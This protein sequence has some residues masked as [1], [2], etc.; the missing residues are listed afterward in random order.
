M[1]NY[2]PEATR[3]RTSL[4]PPTAPSDLTSSLLDSLE[5][6]GALGLLHGAPLPAGPA[7]DATSTE[8][9]LELEAPVNPSQRSSTR[10]RIDTPRGAALKEEL[11]QSEL[12]RKKR[13]PR[14]KNKSKSDDAASTT[15]HSNYNS[16]AG[17]DQSSYSVHRL[18]GQDAPTSNGGGAPSTVRGQGDIRQFLQPATAGAI[19]KLHG[20]PV[21]NSS[22]H[23]GEDSE[24][25]AAAA[26]RVSATS[27]ASTTPASGS[28]PPTSGSCAPGSSPRTS[29]TSGNRSADPQPSTST[30]TNTSCGSTG[31]K[32]S[33]STV[34]LQA[35]SWNFNVGRQQLIDDIK[36]FIGYDA[37]QISTEN[38]KAM[39]EAIVR[40]QTPAVASPERQA[41][42][43]LLRKNPI[44]VGGGHHINRPDLNPNNTDT[45][46]ESESEPE[47]ESEPELIAPQ[48][49]RAHAGARQIDLTLEPSQSPSPLPRSHLPIC[50][51]HGTPGSTQHSTQPTSGTGRWNTTS[52]ISLG[53]PPRPSPLAQ[54]M[55]RASASSQRSFGKSKAQPTS[56]G[57]RILLAGP[58]LAPSRNTSHAPHGLGVLRP[59]DNA[60]QPVR[61]TLRDHLTHTRAHNAVRAVREEAAEQQATKQPAVGSTPPSPRRLSRHQRR[62]RLPPGFNNAVNHIASQLRAHD[63]LTARRLNR[64]S[65]TSSGDTTLPEQTVDGTGRRPST[66]DL[67]EDNEAELAAAGAEASGSELRKSGRK[68]KPAARDVHGNERYILTM[69]KMHLFAYALMEGSYQTRGLFLRWSLPVFEETWSQE[70]PGVAYE[71]PSHQ[72]LQVMVNSLATYRCKVKEAL[73]PLVQYAYGFDKPASTPAAINRNIEIF[74]SIHPNRFHCIDY[75]PPYGHYESD[76]LA[77][78]IAV[79][80]FGSPSS[81]GVMFRSFFSPMPLTVVAF[82]LANMQF[83]I[84][85][86]EHG[87]YSS[88][89][90]NASDMLNKYVA[91]LRGLKEAAAGA[92]ARMNRL[93]DYWFDFGFEYSG[94]MEVDD[95]YTQQIT[96][97][98]DIR[99]DTPD[100]SGKAEGPAGDFLPDD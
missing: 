14:K 78:A 60:G 17:T 68:R 75:L 7:L 59:H 99:P 20:P 31:P 21:Q 25:P 12:R 80:L 69:A 74:R 91:H 48:P 72:A 54:S 16:D 76:I 30:R 93:Q 37:S 65:S 71:P 90:L 84:E 97:R 96:L 63:V 53:N 26:N 62:S 46:T 51:P 56:S 18:P 82:I 70:L 49:I 85:E 6:A 89:D 5:P 15:E 73:R 3:T 42:V 81:I 9:E 2:Q 8:P 33:A 22:S 92:R 35:G 4:L 23:H 77:H 88:H 43:E 10:V 64:Q 67:L 39:L 19:P 36:R 13:K 52:S 40:D 95:P 27:A 94:A 34:N 38:L 79:S 66:P 45:E 83:C 87:Q 32:P 100:N 50:D 41:K 11:K 1:P 28:C 57:S 47:Y 24:S 86:F 98:A 58:R 44:N 55:P 61:Q 29:G